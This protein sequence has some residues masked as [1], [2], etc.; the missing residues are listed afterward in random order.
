MNFEARTKWFGAVMILFVCLLY[1]PAHAAILLDR[2][3]AVVNEEV[4]TWSDLYKMME[5][6]AS[7]QVKRLS[8][9]ERL[10]IFKNNEA[11]FLDKLIDVRLQIQEAKRLG[12][13]VSPEDI[14]ETIENIKKKY[15]LNDQTLG[16]SLKREGL[17]FEDYKKRL[18]D[19]ILISQLINQNIKNKIVI[20]EEEVK[21]YIKS[22]KEGLSNDESFKF[23][24]IFFKK[25][26]DDVDK[27]LIEEKASLVIQKLKAGADFAALA[28][29]YSEDPSGKN[30]GDLG[31]IKKSYMAKE[32]V[33]ILQK[34]KP[35]DFSE[36]FWTESGLHIVKLDEKPPALDTAE[37]E[38]NVRKHLMD[39][40][41]MDKYNSYV[42]SLR[43]K[44]HIEIRL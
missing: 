4:I 42:K 15:S 19:Q 3:V 16:E 1:G 7:G 43:E 6:E 30:G 27:K 21:K 13:S 34:M 26:Q 41:F 5:S 37:T 2:V 40:E 33:E 10:K 18:S 20:S 22:H 39:E 35:G 8:E 14:K 32:F 36:P 23:G 29:E 17:S 24:Q 38:A 12:I 25:P 28:E 9:E 44:A 11:A 31:Y